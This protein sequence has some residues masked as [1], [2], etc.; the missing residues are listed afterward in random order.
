MRLGSLSLSVVAAD[1]YQAPAQTYTD[2]HTR[3]F[4]QDDR[5]FV[6]GH[7]GPA[8]QNIANSDDLSVLDRRKPAV[9]RHEDCRHPG[10]RI[11]Q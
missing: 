9:A 6:D 10:Q 7:H 8:P 3:R 5:P 4:L 2:L 1:G 11:L